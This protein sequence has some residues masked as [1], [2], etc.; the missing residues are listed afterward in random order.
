MP[1]YALLFIVAVLSLLCIYATVI[2]SDLSLK[3]KIFIF[4]LSFNAA[5]MTFFGARDILGRADPFPEPGKYNIRFAE[6]NKKDGK[7]YVYVTGKRHDPN[8]APR[9]L[10]LEPNTL[11]GG[12]SARDIGK[13]LE[14]GQEGQGQLQL[15]LHRR[16]YMHDNNESSINIQDPLRE[17]LPPKEE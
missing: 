8:F 11:N 6:K 14:L 1:R 16:G 7:I 4:I 15:E 12:K 10:L 9:L 5:F 17:F 3:R 13:M 2:A